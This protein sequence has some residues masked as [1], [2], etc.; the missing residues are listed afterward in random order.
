MSNE[1]ELQLDQNLELGATKDPLDLDKDLNLTE[2]GSGVPMGLSNIRGLT[3]QLTAEVGVATMELSDVEQLQS[4]SV[5][6]LSKMEGELTD[7]KIN[8][9][10]IG[11]AQ[12]IEKDGRYGVK[13]VSLNT[14]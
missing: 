11:K 10:Y 4:G 6:M 1:N 5:V 13:V 7:I 9:T 8:G 12:I 14:K 2:K 3:V